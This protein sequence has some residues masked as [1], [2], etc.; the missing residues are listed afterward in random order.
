MS[1]SE[2]SARISRDK[3][4]CQTT[5]LAKINNRIKQLGEQLTD[6]LDPALVSYALEYIDHSESVLAL[7]TLCDFI[8]DGDILITKLEY[9]HIIDLVRDMNIDMTNRYIYINPDNHSS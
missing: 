1:D 6:R 7:E 9:R 4:R 3:I 8:A 5:F 2:V